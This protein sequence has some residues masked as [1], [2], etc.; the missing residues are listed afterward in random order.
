[1]TRHSHLIAGLAAVALVTSWA[2][3]FACPSQADDEAAVIGDIVVEDAAATPAKA[4][5]TTRITFSIENT[6]S[7]NVT[8][9]G[10]RLAVPGPSRVI[11]LLGTSHSARIDGFPLE[12][13]EVS[14][15]DGK[16]AWIEV[17]PLA[18]ALAPGSVLTGRLV[19]GRFEAPL[20]IHVSPEQDLPEKRRFS[21]A[22]WLGWP[23]C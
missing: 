6:G 4:G 19:F 21:S 20:N 15:L 8:I 9:T 2:F 7:D 3:L 5:E 17:G 1:M 10:M 13:G 16:T 14:R 11:G 12:A 22:K 18:S 23:R